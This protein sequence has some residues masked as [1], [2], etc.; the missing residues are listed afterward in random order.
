M[1]L[2]RA[3]SWMTDERTAL[4][5]MALKFARAEAEANLE[6]W[7]RQ[8]RIDR[9][10]FRKAGKLGLLS[11]AVPAEYG[12]GG[13]SSLDDFTVLRAFVRAGISPAPFQIQSNVVPHYIVHYGSEDQ[14][15]R[16]LPGLASGELIGSL[17]MTEAGA[18]S[19]VAAIGTRARRE[20]D[21]YVISGSKIFITNGAQADLVVLAVSTDPRVGRKGLSLIVVD[22]RDCAGFSVGRT[23]HK[24]GHHES[25]TVELVFDEARVPAANLLGEEG[26]GFVMLMRRLPLERMSLAVSALAAIE[27]SVELAIEHINDRESFGRPLIEHQHVRFEIAECVTR[28]RVAGAFLDSCVEQLDRDE[29]DNATAAMAKLWLSE[30]E[31]AI[32]DKCLQLFGGY[33]YITE[34]PIANYYSAARVQRIYG[35][36]NEMMK[37]I[38]GRAARL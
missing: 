30:E 25:D 36:T 38:I 1:E 29:L 18:G 37:E 23:L 3:A 26:D 33:G 34:Y 5:D 24:L 15:Q 17:G 27:R 9:D 14:R 20:G 2:L 19:D 13:G 35:G 10:F 4:A 6:D 21:E 16:W 11:C 7:R 22:T 8:Q 28:A 32:T 31:N 12:G